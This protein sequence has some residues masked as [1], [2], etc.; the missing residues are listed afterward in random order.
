MTLQ[1]HLAVTTACGYVRSL[2][3][4][5]SVR[6]PQVFLVVSAFCRDISS[7]SARSM[8]SFIGLCAATKTFLEAMPQPADETVVQQQVDNIANTLDRMYHKTHPREAQPHKLLQLVRSLPCSDAQTNLLIQKVTR[9]ANKCHADAMYKGTFQGFTSIVSFLTVD[10]AKELGD[11]PQGERL[12]ALLGWAFGLGLRNP[13][14]S[15]FQVLCAMYLMFIGAHNED[16]HSKKRHLEN[17][18]TA[19][20]RLAGP[21][22]EVFLMSLPDT[23]DKFREL[24]PAT[25]SAH[26]GSNP[27]MADVNCFQW[28]TLV[29]SIPMR[30]TRLEL[31]VQQQSVPQ[32]ATENM[33]QQSVLQPAMQNMMSSVMMAVMQQ[34]AAM[35]QALPAPSMLCN[36]R[37]RPALLPG[38]PAYPMRGALSDGQA[39]L[40]DGKAEE[41]PS[42]EQPSDEPASKIAR[43]GAGIAGTAGTTVPAAPVAGGAAPMPSAGTPSRSPLTLAAATAALIQDNAVRKK[44]AAAAPK[45]KAKAKAQAKA[46]ASPKAKAKAHAHAKAKAKAHAIPNMARRLQLRPEGCAKCR[47]AAGC[48]PSCFRANTNPY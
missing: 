41:L 37:G 3:Q 15:T 48:T 9:I 19:F 31:R 23:M 20:R 22:P 40:S 47:G 29:S 7:A 35:N 1:L 13:S 25:F 43:I 28:R 18:K 14:E 32:L 6:H 17:V 39:A 44:P 8:D 46:A 26:F 30:G 34:M 11:L 42:A 4:V 21:R 45:A 16:S 38:I 27:Q 33:Q 10:K 36:T 12:Q 2:L 5:Q 24:C